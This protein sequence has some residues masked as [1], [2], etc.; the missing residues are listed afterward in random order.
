MLLLKDK[1]YLPEVQLPVESLI[2]P[3]FMY[4]L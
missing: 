3:P 4:V 2:Q 1:K